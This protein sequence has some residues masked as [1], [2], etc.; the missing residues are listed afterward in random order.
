MEQPEGFSRLSYTLLENQSIEA[1]SFS[2]TMP[3]PVVATVSK[4]EV[5][6]NSITIIPAQIELGIDIRSVDDRLKRQVEQ[7]I[8]DKCI[9]LEKIHQ[10]SIHI[11]KFVDNSSVLLDHYSKKGCFT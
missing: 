5:K 6:P 2:Q 3:I 8:R 10:V 9:E 11:E 4:I 1:L 7:Q